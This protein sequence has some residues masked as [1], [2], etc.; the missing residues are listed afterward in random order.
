[1]NRFAAMETFVKVYETGS[2][3]GAARLLRVGQPAVSK[4]VAQ[5]ED[6]LGVALLLRSTHGLTPTQGGEDFYEHA[7]RA[8]EEADEAELAA[9]GDSSSISGRIRVCAAVT[10]A[11]LHVIPRLPAFLAQYPGIEVDVLLNDG[12]IDLIENGVNLALRMGK[13]ADSSLTARKIGQSPRRVL[14]TPEYFGRAGKPLVPAELSMHEFVIH[15]L[16]GQGNEW[17]FE[18]AGQKTAVTVGGRLRTNAAEGVREGVFSGIGMSVTSEWMFMP[19]LA[20]GRVESVL[21]DWTLPPVDLWVVFPSGR[22]INART[23]AFVDF[24]EAEMKSSS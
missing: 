6:R 7:R 3:S 19:E 8:L 5:L 23:R 12:N 21:D 18:R 1:M 4:A 11:R 10:F 14:G 20:S 22:R 9:R 13:L 15:D 2:F 17:I 24:I 16:S